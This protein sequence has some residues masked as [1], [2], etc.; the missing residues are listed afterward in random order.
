MRSAHEVDVAARHLSSIPLLHCAAHADC[1]V[2]GLD[3]KV[4][5]ALCWQARHSLGALCVCRSGLHWAQQ[6]GTL[7]RTPAVMLAR[8]QAGAGND[9]LYAFTVPAELAA[10]DGACAT[11]TAC[12]DAGQV[13]VMA[14]CPLETRCV[15]FM[16]ALMNSSSVST[17]DLEA[18]GWRPRDGHKPAAQLAWNG[19]GAENYGPKVCKGDTAW[20]AVRQVAEVRSPRAIVL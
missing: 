8:M 19:Q 13:A 14:S 20:S 17:A 3:A 12:S 6:C 9:W 18:M 11:L 4:C 10:G 16:C 7:L 1:C 5:H 2:S 15:V